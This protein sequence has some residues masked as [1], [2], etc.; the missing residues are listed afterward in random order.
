MGSQDVIGGPASAQRMMRQPMS[1]TSM[2]NPSY[3]VGYGSSGNQQLTP[4]PS[5]QSSPIPSPSPVN[6]RLIRTSQVP[7]SI[8]KTGVVLD[9]RGNLQSISMRANWTPEERAVKRRIVRFWREQ[10]GTTIKLYFKPLGVGERSL[11]HMKNEQC[12]S[13]IYWE[14]GDECYI[15]SVDTIYLLALMFG[16]TLGDSKEETAEKNR[17]RRNLQTYKPA[18]VSKS[19]VSR[20]GPPKSWVSKSPSFFELVMSFP[21]PKPSKIK[22]DV[23]VFEWS[24]LEQ[25]L[26]KIVSKYVRS[27]FL[28]ESTQFTNLY[29]SG[30]PASVVVDIKRRPRLNYSRAQRTAGRGR[31]SA[32]YAQTPESMTLSPAAVPH[33]LPSYQQS[34][35]LQQ[36]ASPAS[37]T[38]SYS[39]SGLGSPY[40]PNDAFKSPY[41][42]HASIPSPLSAYTNSDI[43][44]GTN[45]P[46]STTE[47]I[48]T[49][50]ND[51]NY[52]ARPPYPNAYGVG[53]HYA[54][55]QFC[56]EVSATLGLPGRASEDLAAYVGTGDAQS[57]DSD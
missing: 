46:A 15:T 24:E 39:V 30:I 18:T 36:Q 4:A 11:P 57:V 45:S 47:D 1:Q 56:G 33:G 28:P 25:A 17:I 55:Q 35:P 29:Q 27:I 53:G 16:I 37:L 3:G 7:P 2:W 23:K 40:T 31:A 44:P 14:E 51:Y 54:V 13:C 52:S 12:I 21:D 6:P 5:F 26:N 42:P 32:A 38:H 49:S 22:K 9:I 8:P 43:G 19:G 48:I 50:S 41:T 34:S 20:S 10:S